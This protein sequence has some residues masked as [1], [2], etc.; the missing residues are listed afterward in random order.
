MINTTTILKK[1]DLRRVVVRA[2]HKQGYQIHKGVLELKNQDRESKRNA[3]IL[4]KAERILEQ[5]KFVLKNIPFIQKHLPDGKN[6]EIDKIQPKLIEVKAGTK[7]EI[8]FRWWSLVWWS[9]P[10]ERA[11]GRQI[12]FIVWDEYHKAPMGLIGL[13]SPILSWSVRD[14]VLGIKSEDRDYWV[15]QSMSA[16]RLGALPPY[17]NILG[18]KLIAALVTSDQ[19]RKVFR[20]KYKNVLTVIKERKIPADLL[21]ITTTGAYGKSSVYSRLKY[22]GREIASFIGYSNGNGSFH[23]PNILY[24]N[25]LRYL[26]SKDIDTTR[27]YG[28]GPSRKLRI[29]NQAMTLL[30]FEKGTQHSIQRGVYLF[31][32]AENVKEVIKKG[33]R[34]KWIK[35]PVAGLN[36]YW[37]NRWAIPRSERDKSYLE[38]IS[39]HFIKNTREELK[40]FKETYGTI[41]YG[42]K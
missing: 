27:G 2:L 1:K 38:F 31:P 39:E 15:N 23:I 37:K 4:A 6:L 14:K 40:G 21:F 3:H 12:R 16:Q 26:E 22:E 42:R 8:M 41:V 20:R 13:Q 19:V 30:G 9:L 17:N 33:E 35:R 28:A 10:N 11:Y 32:L 24:Q 25:L 7:W 36:E 29:I 18:G 5:E 34:P